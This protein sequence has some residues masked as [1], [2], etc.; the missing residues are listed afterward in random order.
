MAGVRRCIERGRVA[1]RIDLKTND[2]P[3]VDLDHPVVA[4]V[5]DD[6]VAIV[7]PFGAGGIVELIAG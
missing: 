3:A 5:G 7:T 4:L 1:E 6:D 2:I